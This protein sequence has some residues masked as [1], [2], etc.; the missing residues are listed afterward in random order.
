MDETF[1][2]DHPG[3]DW[4]RFHSPANLLALRHGGQVEPCSL[5]DAVLQEDWDHDEEEEE[6]SGINAD[7]A[8]E[9][10]VRA[11]Q[12][13]SSGHEKLKRKFLD[14]IAELAANKKGGHAVA[15]ALMKEEEIKVTIWVARNNG[16]T[17]V[18]Q[19]AFGK[20]GTALSRTACRNGTVSRS[21]SANKN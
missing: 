2:W 5:S 20:A 15:C 12:I 6:E 16:F 18:D 14:C 4:H 1:S 13:A 8:S 9:N 21:M 17:G 7:A 10:T 11:H 19:S 3:L